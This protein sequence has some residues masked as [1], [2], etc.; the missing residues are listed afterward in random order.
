MYLFSRTRLAILSLFTAHPLQ[1]LTFCV[2]GMLMHYLLPIL[3]PILEFDIQQLSIK[4]F[5]LGLLM[6]LLNL[7]CT[8]YSPVSFLV[9][10]STLSWSKKTDPCS[11]FRHTEQLDC[12]NSK[13]HWYLLWRNRLKQLCMHSKL[14][15]RCGLFFH[16]CS[17]SRYD[18]P[19][20]SLSHFVY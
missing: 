17:A 5:I 2:A 19:K 12:R 16:S 15:F 4:V 3:N 1:L 18:N 20:N 6:L 9:S 13:F 11:S 7:S 14:F 8:W 10:T